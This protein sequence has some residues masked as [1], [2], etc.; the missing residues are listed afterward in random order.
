MLVYYLWPQLGLLLLN[1]YHLLGLGQL[2]PS[3]CAQGG[4]ESFLGDEE[5]IL[6][7]YKAFLTHL[8]RGG[9]AGGVALLDDYDPDETDDEAAKATKYHWWHG[10]ACKHRRLFV[11][12]KGH[13]GL[14]PRV[15]QP[16]DEVVIL[17]GFKTPML[18][19]P[20]DTGEY[21]LVGH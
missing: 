1:R 15:M 6:G 21:Q 16:K 19:R 18:L 8:Q 14:G 17:Y 13:L 11:T 7:Y 5:T 3:L 2:L 12:V 20:L 4:Y 10:A 9:F